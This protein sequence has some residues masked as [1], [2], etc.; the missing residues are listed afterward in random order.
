MNDAVFMFKYVLRRAW[1]KAPR[2]F[3]RWEYVL[4]RKRMP[5]FTASTHIAS[6]SSAPT[7]WPKMAEDLMD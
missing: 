4:N 7:D 1:T 3:L 2:R 6:K 5:S